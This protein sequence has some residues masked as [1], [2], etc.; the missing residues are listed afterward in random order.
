MSIV[1]EIDRA[2]ED[3]RAI[4]Q[5]L[6]KVR[7][8]AITERLPKEHVDVLIFKGCVYIG[9]WDGHSWR[10]NDIGLAIFGVTHWMPLPEPPKEAK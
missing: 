10:T 1:A 8:V 9:S 3:L 2:M 6:A 5:E 7:W 4:R